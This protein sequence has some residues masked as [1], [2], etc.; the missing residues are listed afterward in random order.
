MPRYPYL[1]LDSPFI[2]AAA[3]TE[4]D[5][6]EY[7]GEVQGELWGWWSGSEKGLTNGGVVWEL[8]N[9]WA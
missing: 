9:V 4:S 5:L 8:S 3:P 1:H 6:S 7:R 2:S